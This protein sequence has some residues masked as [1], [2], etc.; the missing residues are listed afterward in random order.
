MSAAGEVLSGFLDGTI[1]PADFVLRYR[2]GGA[3][4]DET[5]L[6]LRGDGR[7][8]AFSTATVGGRRLEYA[9][10]LPREDVRALVAA[11]VDAR[12]WEAE[13]VVRRQPKGDVPAVIA[14]SGGGAEAEVGLWA[15][16]IADV[17]QFDAAQ[18]AVLAL[19]RRVSDGAVVEPGR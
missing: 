12:V 1:A 16:E 17:P 3:M 2:I 13:H 4:T 11:L 7:Y 5:A 14:V 9:G 15:S 19:I 6:E 18:A 10:E 8:E